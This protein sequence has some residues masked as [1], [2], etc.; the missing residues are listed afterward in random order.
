MLIPLA[1]GFTCAL[2]T[3]N[4]LLSVL[5]FIRYRKEEEKNRILLSMSLVF[6]FMA[7]SRIFFLIFDYFQAH[8]DPTLVSGPYFLTWKLASTFILLGLGFFFIVADYNVYKGRDKYAL[9]IAY[10]V[11][12][13][14][15][16]V[17]PVFPIAELFSGISMFIALLFIPI[18]YI[19]IAVKTSDEL[20]RKALAIV[21]GMALY[22]T[23]LVLLIQVLISSTASLMALDIITV[24][25]VIHIISVL[26][27]IA[28]GA[29]I[30]YGFS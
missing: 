3:F 2:I 21:A 18:S 19:Y 5:F 30:Y 9:T 25:C 22:G 27:R 29:I 15:I 20:R 28:G 16:V 12:G 1:I 13:V 14:I 17:I 10:A 23:G 4:F 6:L 7:I 26:F 8:F 11:A 24:A